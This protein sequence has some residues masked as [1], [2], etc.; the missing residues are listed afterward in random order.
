[1]P[2]IS[3]CIPMYNG[4]KYL[5]ECLDSVLAQAY[6]DFEVL[7]VDDR[8]ND[9]TPEI[10]REYASRD[11]RFRLVRNEANLGLVKN[12]NRCVELAQGEW[13]KFV[14]QD[15]LLAPLCLKRMID[16][17]S[18][19]DAL[20]SC[21][22]TI[23]FEPGIS[24]EIK[25]RYHDIPAMESLFGALT[26]IDAGTFAGAVLD[27]PL[28]FIGEP[29]AVM[30]HRSVFGRYGYFNHSFAH[31]C[32]MEY[33][34]RVGV[35]TG[36]VYV[37]ETLATFRAHRDS[38][39]AEN[40]AYLDLQSSYF[41]EVML[42][43]EFVF[44][45]GFDVLRDAAKKREPPVDLAKELAK[46]AFRAEERA[47]RVSGARTTLDPAGSEE[48]RKL[49]ARYPE[50]DTLFALKL[51]RARAWLDKHILWRFNR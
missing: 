42:F 11:P 18:P 28:N 6:P 20:I 47:M 35:H 36:L 19:E 30:V 8:S 43:H 46:K 16:S 4:Q 27:A 39:S 22:R 9:G 21:G 33:W 34:F 38:R 23:L 37:P 40:F 5:R 32:D 1:M 3:V 2:K 48:W 14:F 26:K 44:A 41:D 24:D 49:L 31:L 13:I 45:P 7:M 17:A 50:I 51:L 10:A 25:K 12:W 15:D 29:T